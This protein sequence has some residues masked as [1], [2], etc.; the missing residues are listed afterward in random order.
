MTRRCTR[1]L[2]LALALASCDDSFEYAP[3]VTPAS[4]SLWLLVGLQMNLDRVRPYLAE[5]PGKSVR[6]ERVDALSREVLATCEFLTAGPVGDDELRAARYRVDLIAVAWGLI[7]ADLLASA[8]GVGGATHEATLHGLAWV[9]SGLAYLRQEPLWPVKNPEEADRISLMAVTHRDNLRRAI[10]AA[11]V[12]RDGV[13]AAA[14]A[15]GAIT[16]VRLVGAGTAA[17][18]RVLG[19]LGEAGEGPAFVTAGLAGGIGSVQ[20]L[21]SGRTLALTTEEVIALAN[22][23]AI[24]AGA[25]AVFMAAS[26]LHHICTNKNSVSDRQG[27]PWTPRF[28]DFFK[29]AGMTLRDPENLVRIKAHRGPHPQAYHEEVMKA[30]QEGTRGVRANT[31]EYRQALKETLTRLAK[32]IRTPGTRLNKLVTGVISE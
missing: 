17:L 27:G 13:N 28:E 32:Q 15:S 5:H 18:G 6:P 31:Q 7:Q 4:E 21:A 23:G 14:L 10:P 1:F 22:A 29:K 24:S 3:R 11:A 9:S 8:G 30:L 19:F 25:F 2:L 20:V 16:T 12:M 26:D